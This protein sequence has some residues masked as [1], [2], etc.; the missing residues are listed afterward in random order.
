MIT[1]QIDPAVIQPQDETS[2]K[3]FK[4]REEISKISKT[5]KDFSDELKTR[6][7]VST[8]DKGEMIANSILAFRHL[9]DASMR[10][11]KVLQAKNGGVSILSR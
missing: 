3:C 5:L 2:E 6:V 4:L 11:G 7:S 8:E 1:T 9:E 10:I